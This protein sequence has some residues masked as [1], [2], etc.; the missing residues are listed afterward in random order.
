M[1]Q[2][3][4]AAAPVQAGIEIVQPQ[5]TKAAQCLRGKGFVELDEVEI[6]E[7]EVQARKQFFGGGHRTHAHDTRQDA[8]GGHAQD[9]GPRVLEPIV[10]LEVTVPDSAMG[11][12]TG[13][14]ASRRARIQGTDT[15]G[16][17]LTNVA[18]AVPL[19]VL[20]DFPTE[21]KSLTGGEGRYT[22]SFS[23]YEAVPGH[24]QKELVEQHET[25]DSGDD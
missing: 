21:L 23:H 7:G 20:T 18:A 25:G 6:I 14:L 1:S 16:G 10:D 24:V 12:V 13:A 19:S 3:D 22:M 9:A 5:F 15:V 11:D 2:S 8:G 17:G 4:G